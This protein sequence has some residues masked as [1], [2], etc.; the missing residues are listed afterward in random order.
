MDLIKLFGVAGLLA[1]TLG[2][3][4]KNRKNQNI[5]FIVGG[6]LLEIYSIHQKDVIFIVLQVVFTAAAAFNL[7]KQMSKTK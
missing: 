1:V 2:I 6:V 3:L 7:V 4:L 5:L